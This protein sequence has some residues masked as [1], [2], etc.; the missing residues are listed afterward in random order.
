MCTPA[1]CLA[2]KIPLEAAA[3]VGNGARQVSAQCDE[4]VTNGVMA[5]CCHAF[6]T[7]TIRCLVDVLPVVLTV[8]TDHAQKVPT[9]HAVTS[10]L[11]KGTYIL[12]AAANF[13]FT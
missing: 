2:T 1:L 7:R 3:C 10:T 5:T 12:L 11:R 6:C 13:R 4:S 9:W 8:L